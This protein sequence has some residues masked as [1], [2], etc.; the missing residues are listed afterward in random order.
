G[1]IEIVRRV[2]SIQIERRP[3]EIRSWRNQRAYAGLGGRAVGDVDGEA[4]GRGVDQIERPAARNHVK[5]TICDV[6]LTSAANWQVVD[7][8]RCVIEGLVVAGNS[9]LGFRV[10]EIDARVVA[11]IVLQVTRRIVNGLGPRER[12]DEIQSTRIAFLQLRLQTV[13]RAET[14]VIGFFNG[15]ELR[16]RPPRIDGQILAGKVW[17][18]LVGVGENHQANTVIPTYATSSS[19]LCASSCCTVKCQLWT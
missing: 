18:S 16:V 11:V 5:S 2:R 8:R 17:K 9:A 4:R 13:V 3:R 14:A 10:I 1:E 19:R 12:V 7:H 6:E 15:G